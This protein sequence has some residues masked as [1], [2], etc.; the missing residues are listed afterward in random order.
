MTNTEPFIHSRLDFQDLMLF[1]I[2]E[3]LLVASPY[4]A[5]VL[6]EGGRLTEQILQEYHGMNFNYPPRVWQ[7]QSGQQAL[8]LLS[9][10]KIDLVLIMT[11]ISDIDPLELA[12]KIKE[13]YKKKPVILLAFDQ[14]E[15]ND[16]LDVQLLSTLPID[17]IFL[18]NGH[19]DVLL[20]II[21]YIEDKR[22]ASRDIKKGQVRAIIFI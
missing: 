4:D 6:E 22:N 7:A 18:W 21:K 16:L 5:F 10:R 8:D 9:K 13:T 19:A 12:S 3:I 20:A 15:V 2:Y 1:R 17:N 11:R 14:S